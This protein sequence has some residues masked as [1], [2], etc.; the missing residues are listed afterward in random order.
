MPIYRSGIETRAVPGDTEVVSVGLKTEAGKARE[1]RGRNSEGRY[2]GGIG[3]GRKGGRSWVGYLGTARAQFGRGA[4]GPG[5]EKPSAGGARGGVLQFGR[6]RWSCFWGRCR[7]AGGQGA[8]LARRAKL[9]LGW[10]NGRGAKLGGG[11]ARA[12]FGRDGRSW[13]KGERPM[14]A[15]RSCFW[16]GPMRAGRNCLTR[17]SLGGK[18][19]AVFKRHPHPAGVGLSSPS[20]QPLRR[21]QSLRG[22]S[23]VFRG[24]KTSALT[25]PLRGFAK[26]RNYPPPPMGLSSHLSELRKTDDQGL[27]DWCPPV[28]R[29]THPKD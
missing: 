20:D 6:N 8:K 7:P 5:G 15:G 22:F 2:R 17:H 4:A 1:T 25:I 11:W 28:M 9:F 19:E 3:G 23:H 18:G 14:R 29:D 27:I 10:A 26:P 12:Q 21:L 24:L 13:G 16:A